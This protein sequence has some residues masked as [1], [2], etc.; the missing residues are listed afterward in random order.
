MRYSY[1]SRRH[2]SGDVD[3]YQLDIR[4]SAASLDISYHRYAAVLPP[5]D[6]WTSY[7][8][9]I[10]RHMH[11]TN[12]TGWQHS[13]PLEQQHNL[14]KYPPG[15]KLTQKHFDTALHTLLL[16][17]TKNVRIKMIYTR[18][19]YVYYNGCMYNL[20]LHSYKNMHK[21]VSFIKSDIVIKCIVPC[22][23]YIARNIVLNY[24]TYIILTCRVW[25]DV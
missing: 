13:P 23:S 4:V 6:S 21:N 17:L 8:N 10:Q 19:V 22:W 2:L 14:T 1:L 7:R 16:V 18:C 5:Y 3:R 12:P 9:R 11:S 25:F 15:A 24:N 20:S